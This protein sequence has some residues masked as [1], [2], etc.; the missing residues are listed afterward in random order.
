MKPSVV[1]IGYGRFGK[2]F[3]SLLKR[4]CRIFIIE[5]KKNIIPERG[6]K[7]IPLEEI[8]GKNFIIL[9]VPI[10][11]VENIV[12][13]I[14]PFLSN[15]SVVCDVCSVKEQPILQMKKYLSK[16]ISIIGTH[17]L[18]GPDS[19]GGIKNIIVCPAR[20]SKNRLQDFLMIL[21]E[22]SMIPEKMSALQHDELI[23][24]SLF[25]AQ[26]IGRSLSE[27][28]LPSEKITTLN[29]TMLRHIAHTSVRDSMELFCDMY[30]YNRF[31]KK[32]PIQIIT[33]MKQLM[34]KIQI[35][36]INNVAKI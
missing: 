13:Q 30:R 35:E 5:K 28:N 22:S 36:R 25:V 6:I 34:K 11:Q 14:A 7:K 21:K 26:F 18:F 33:A 27:I 24:H 23:A 8:R 3:A 1:I 12:Q 32:I 17:P 31:A 15:N 2:T 4:H 19:V 29:S 20:I 16:A 10:N 9:A